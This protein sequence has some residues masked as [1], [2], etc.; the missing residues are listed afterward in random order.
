[1]AADGSIIID[2][3]IDASGMRD[4]V[5]E[6]KNLEK[7]AKKTDAAIESMRAKMGRH[8]ELGGSTEDRQYRRMQYDLAQLEI[9]QADVEEAIDRTTNAY[10]SATQ[11]SLENTKEEV[12]NSEEKTQALDRVRESVR[13]VGDEAEKAQKKA[14]R[15]HGLSLK[16]IIA[17]SLGIHGLYSV[18][19]K[20]R[21]A[22]K[23]AFGELA[24]ANP[25]FGAALSN[26]R[27]ALDTLKMNVGAAI[28]PIA[29]AVLPILTQLANMLSIAAVKV[30]EFFAALT[31]KTT[32]QKVKSVGKAVAGVGG[33]IDKALAAYDKLD[34][35]SSSKGSGGGSGAGGGIGGAGGVEWEEVEIA[36]GK[37]TKLAE[38]VKDSVEIVAG[39]IKN[40]KDIVQMLMDDDMED[41]VERF[42]EATEGQ[43]KY[44]RAF[45]RTFLKMQ[46]FYAK[47]GAAIGD[48]VNKS[49]PVLH[50]SLE[51]VGSKDIQE[52]IDTYQRIYRNNMIFGTE[53]TMENVAK[54]MFIELKSYAERGGELTAFSYLN[55][56]NYPFKISVDKN[57]RGII[58]WLGNEIDLAESKAYG[59][60]GKVLEAFANSFNTASQSI[61]DRL[62]EAAANI[63]GAVKD[64]AAEAQ[65]AADIAF[66]SD[67]LKA[68]G[69]N[70]PW[71]GSTTAIPAIAAGTVTPTSTAKAT[72][73]SVTSG[74]SSLAGSM[75]NVVNLVLNGKQIAQ[76]VWDENEKKYK[77]TGG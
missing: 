24:K 16:R 66:F 4:Y 71:T 8:L 10:N 29:E 44:L 32:I 75:N 15:H 73:A 38:I 23:E 59:A 30:Q 28:M 3:K 33:A 43:N 18:F 72:A 12:Q 17:Y 61:A 2:T 6:L 53:E 25:Q 48:L 67:V 51:G 45:Q 36:E 54:R 57:G 13:K 11:V 40:E 65:K 56:F 42:D 20:M 7:E 21:S 1:M 34:V 62:K 5:A 31:G 46:V 50:S 49:T 39:S 58:E 76:A 37:A 14:S 55:S 74:V 47:T 52:V 60:G 26:F 70:G 9:K 68:N 69:I 27:G 64:V 22:A 77:Q 19:S 41:I 63:V 35:I